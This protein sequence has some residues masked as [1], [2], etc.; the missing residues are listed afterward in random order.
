MRILSSWQQIAKYVGR[1]VRTVQRWEIEFGL[2]VRR[3]GHLESKIVV[4]DP[5]EIDAW[6]HAM[7]TRVDLDPPKKHR[8]KAASAG[9]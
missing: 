1:S 7:P 3:P 9:R 2:P 8:S 6:I 5:G 4:A